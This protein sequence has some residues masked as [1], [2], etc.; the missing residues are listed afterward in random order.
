MHEFNGQ[1]LATLKLN[2][3]FKLLLPPFSG[4]LLDNV[5][6]EIEKDHAVIEVACQSSRQQLPPGDRE[7]RDLLQK[8]REIDRHFVR[9]AHIPNIGIQI[10]HEEIE[11]IRAERIRLLLDGLYRIL[12]QWEKQ[13]AMR[14][15]VQAILDRG[16]FHGLILKILYLYIDETRLLSNSIKLPLTLRRARDTALRTVTA[17]MQTAAAKVADEC[18]AIMFGMGCRK[19]P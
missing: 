19:P 14:K 7:I 18:A 5:E 13:P 3:F 11:S 6:K 10:R 9:K 4:F 12:R 17:A 1:T 8:A 16:Q 15:A 2:P